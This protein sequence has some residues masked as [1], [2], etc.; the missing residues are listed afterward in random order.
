[1][2]DYET[3]YTN[4]DKTCFEGG[5]LSQAGLLTLRVAIV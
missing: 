1:M 2:T 5:E 4:L 3:R